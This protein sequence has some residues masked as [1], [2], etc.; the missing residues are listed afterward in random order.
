[1]R[2]AKR[3]KERIIGGEKR[4][5]LF[6]KWNGMNACRAI[7]AIYANAILPSSQGVKLKFCINSLED[8]CYLK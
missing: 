4:G 7:Q 5:F 8:M 3:N 6:I 2:L 1:V